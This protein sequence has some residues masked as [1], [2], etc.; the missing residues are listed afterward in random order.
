MIPVGEKKAAGLSARLDV[1][2]L[3]AEG[4]VALVEFIV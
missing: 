1:G 2:L 4:W 3:E